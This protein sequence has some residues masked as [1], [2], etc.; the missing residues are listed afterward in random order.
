M[1]GGRCENRFIDRQPL[2]LA[3]QLGLV[4]N[5]ILANRTRRTTGL[6]SFQ[7]DRWH[8]AFWKSDRVTEVR[9]MVERQR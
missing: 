5:A 1:T 2:L 7:S 9:V 6:C 4:V 3:L 8:F